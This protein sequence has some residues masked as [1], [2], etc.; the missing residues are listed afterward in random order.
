MREN[1]EKRRTSKNTES[2]GG[3]VGVKDL[4]GAPGTVINLVFRNG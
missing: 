3:G 4:V 2:R 1:G